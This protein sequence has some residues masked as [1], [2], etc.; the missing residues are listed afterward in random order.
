VQSLRAQ[1]LIDK[2]QLA[3]H[4][5]G[6]FYRE[7][8]RAPMILP[9]EGLPSGFKGQRSA[10]T[11]IYFL[12]QP[13]MFSAFH[14]IQSDELWHFYAGHPLL[15]HV[16]EKLGEYSQI[17]LG[18]DYEAGQVFQASVAAGCWFGSEL[19]PGGQL[20]LVGCTVAPGFDF[21]DFE[22]ASRRELTG[23]YP[24]HR[25]LIHRLTRS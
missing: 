17:E 8:Y 7:T 25:E 10:S 6:G 15:V 3:P 9:K 19:K 23:M 2:F 11:A 4:P 14:R 21:E 16:I 5:E 18:P 22:I 13:G 12:L 1:D 20:A 24:Q